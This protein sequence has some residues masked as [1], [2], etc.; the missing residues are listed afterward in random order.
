MPDGVLM[1][2]LAVETQPKLAGELVSSGCCFP[3]PYQESLC[4]NQEDCI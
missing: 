4:K 1:F 3:Y 2:Y